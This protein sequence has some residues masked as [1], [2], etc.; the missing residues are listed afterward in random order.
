M[1]GNKGT[2]TLVVVTYGKARHIRNMKVGFR[3]YNHRKE[4]DKLKLMYGVC[5]HGGKNYLSYNSISK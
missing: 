3:S 1:V 4:S 2:R 5:R